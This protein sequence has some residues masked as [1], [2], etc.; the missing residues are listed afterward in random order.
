VCNESKPQGA[1]ASYPR[2]TK[3]SFSRESQRV[4]GENSY[5]KN[6]ALNHI[7]KTF[8]PSST[9]RNDYWYVILTSLINFQDKRR[10]LGRPLQLQQTSTPAR[11]TNRLQ[12]HNYHISLSNQHPAAIRGPYKLSKDSFLANSPVATTS[13]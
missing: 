4:P 6:C 13:D 12:N 3:P 7:T 9:G 11:I 5:S 8:P 1:T 10:P 2:D